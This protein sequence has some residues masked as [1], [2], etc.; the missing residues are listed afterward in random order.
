MRSLV[1]CVPFALIGFVSCFG[2]PKPEAWQRDLRDL[3]QQLIER[4]VDLFHTVSREEFES[5]VD[6]LHARIPELSPSERLV[7]IARIVAMVGDG[8]TSFYTAEQKKWRFRCYP[9]RLWSFPDGIYV[10]G[11]TAE[12]ADLL[13]KR[14]VRIH[15]TPIEEAFRRVSTTVGADNPVE[16]DYSVPFQLFRS[17]L[18]HALDIAPSAEQ[19]TFHFEDGSSAA[20]PS[21]TVK[22]WLDLDWR[23]ANG[24]YGGEAPPSMRLEF[25][26]ASP[27]LLEHLPRR[28]YYWFTWLED[29]RTLYFHYR[30]CWD[31]KGRPPFAEVVGDLFRMMDERPVERLVVDL[32]HNT[33]GEPEIARPLIEGLRERSAFTEEGRLFVLVSRRTFSAALT[34]A[35]ELRSRTNARIVG[36]PPRGKPNNPSEGRDIKLRRTR[37]WATVSTQFVERDP[38]LGDQDFLPV[39]IEVA[40]SFDQFRRGEDPVLEAALAAELSADPS[41][42]LSA[43]LSS[44]L[45]R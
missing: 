42:D 6:D 2:E 40:Q 27:F 18:L 3:E 14:L 9:I 8:H 12:H 1:L 16:H 21:F 32:R 4:H 29:E 17:E 15:D 33:G 24:I 39:E 38:A 44:D 10:I 25:I 37:L 35:A 19:A 13:G 36:E 31:Q 34:N 45:V 30:N 28:E 20:L 23:A 22:E 26:F 11:A 41:A 43:G 7:G 5:A